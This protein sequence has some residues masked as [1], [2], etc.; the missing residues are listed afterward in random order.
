MEAQSK[1]QQALEDHKE[2]QV[3]LVHTP[4]YTPQVEEAAPAALVKQIVVL[5]QVLVV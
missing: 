1:A 3:E 4:L 5:L 2:M